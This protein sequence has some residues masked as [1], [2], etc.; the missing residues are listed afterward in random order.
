MNFKMMKRNATAS[1]KNRGAAFAEQLRRARNA[2]TFCAEQIL[3]PSAVGSRLA[4]VRFLPAHSYTRRHW[5]DG[6][7]PSAL[8]SMN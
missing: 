6:T 7:R 3:V 2:F 8:L 5:A 4:R 1:W